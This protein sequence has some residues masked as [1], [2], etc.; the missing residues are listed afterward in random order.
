M[1]ALPTIAL[2]IGD[3]AEFGPDRA[4]SPGRHRTARRWHIG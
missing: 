1:S 3:P 2:T 4:Q